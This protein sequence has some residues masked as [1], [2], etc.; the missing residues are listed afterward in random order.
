MTAHHRS[1]LRQIAR[2]VFAVFLVLV[3][4]LLIRYARSVDWSQV[5]AA[6]DGYR[7]PTLLAAASLTSLSYLIYCGYDLAARAYSGHDLSTRRV[8]AIAFT[9]YTFSLNIGALVG[10]A[11]FRY[12]LYSRSGLGAGRISR[13]IGFAVIIEKCFIAVLAVRYAADALTRRRFAL[14]EHGF[15]HC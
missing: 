15:Y 14:I 5:I 12:R 4:I 8:M 3:A 10:S 1:R 13:I 2:V 7:L 9:S 6:I 11:G